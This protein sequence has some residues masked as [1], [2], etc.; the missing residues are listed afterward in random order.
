[1]IVPPNEK[2]N[3]PRKQCWT[4]VRTC[5]SELWKWRGEGRQTGQRIGGKDLQRATEEREDAVN[6]AEA[7]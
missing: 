1:M 2:K 4:N 6:Q 3:V 5:F 7:S